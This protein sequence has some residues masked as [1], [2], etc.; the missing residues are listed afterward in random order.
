VTGTGLL[1]RKSRSASTAFALRMPLPSN[2]TGRFASRSAAATWHTSSAEGWPGKF[3]SGTK[4]ASSS[5]TTRML[6]MSRGMSIHTGPGLPDMARNSALSSSWAMLAGSVIITAY[7]VMDATMLTM[8]ASCWPKVRRAFPVYRVVSA[9]V[10]WPEMKMQ[11]RPSCHADR[12]PVRVL[13]A[14][15]PVDTRQ[16]P[17]PPECWAYAAAAKAADCSW[18]MHTADM[19]LSL[20]TASVRNKAPRPL[21]RKTWRT[22][23]AWSLSIT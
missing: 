21:T 5:G 11:G 23:C 20:A 13:V 18:C 12:T 17:G 1:A 8:S 22:P 4:R 10:F 19:V 2:S 3:A 6:W 16:T 9:R 7:L 15:Q 14:A